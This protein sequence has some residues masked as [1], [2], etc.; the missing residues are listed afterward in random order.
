MSSLREEGPGVG[1]I[2]DLLE[3]LFVLVWLFLKSLI[4]LAVAVISLVRGMI[5][6]KD[7]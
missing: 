2:A 1:F 7:G 3:A 5:T 4:E 6:G